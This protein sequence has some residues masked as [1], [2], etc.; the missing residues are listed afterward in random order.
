MPKYRIYLRTLCAYEYE[1]GAANELDAITEAKELFASQSPAE[2]LNHQYD[3]IF[4]DASAD[5]IKA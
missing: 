4:A 5:E 2:N 3:F 1:I